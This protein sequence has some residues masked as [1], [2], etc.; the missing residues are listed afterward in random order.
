MYDFVVL[1][2]ADEAIRQKRSTGSKKFSK[3]DFRKRNNAQLD[4]DK[5]IKMADFVFFNNGSKKE[6][7][8]KA[9]LLISILNSFLNHKD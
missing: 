5:K 7:E 9:L 4:E 6:L 2:S 3:E 8:R 1:I